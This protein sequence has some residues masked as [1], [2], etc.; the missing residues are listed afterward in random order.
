MS[1][2]D[3]NKQ[4]E[5]SSVES[6]YKLNTEAVDRLVNASKKTYPKTNVDPGKKY[7][8]KGFLD[9]IPEP[10]KALFIKFWFNGAVCF[11]IFW[12]LGLY[13]WDALDMAVV[14]A[15][16]LGMVNDLLVNNT[17]HFFAVTPGSNN[18]WMM[19]PQKKFWT[20]FANIV[21]SFLVLLIVIWLYNAI[22]IAGNMI[23]GTEG[24]IYLGVEPILFGIF[25]VAVDMLFVSMKNLAIRIISDA[26]DKTR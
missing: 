15:V 20:F 26:K 18:K 12:G 13:I 7:R 19:F 11:F 8:S 17:F 16:V 5:K 3:K 10:I 14:M 4:N 1:K 2:K 6:S 25:Y 9:K 22:N 21:Y 24:Q 23:S